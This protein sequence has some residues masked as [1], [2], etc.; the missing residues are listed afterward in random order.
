M[1]IYLF[2]SLVCSFL[3]NAVSRRCGNTVVAPAAVADAAD[4]TKQCSSAP[5]SSQRDR[6]PPMLSSS[7]FSFLTDRSR[8]MERDLSRRVLD[9][10]RRVL[11]RERRVLERERRLVFDRERLVRDL[12]IQIHFKLFACEEVVLKSPQFS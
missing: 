1:F 7:S 12:K 3:D 6:M 11:D 10:E 5:Q 4:A 8:L 9:L 2:S